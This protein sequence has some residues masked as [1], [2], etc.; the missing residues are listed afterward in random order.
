MGV[1]RGRGQTEL[2]ARGNDIGGERRVGVGELSMSDG[3]IGVAL[4]H[5]RAGAQQR[6]GRRVRERGPD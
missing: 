2:A 1:T 4:S 3:A 6:V 5:S